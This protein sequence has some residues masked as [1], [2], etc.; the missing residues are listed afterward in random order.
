MVTWIWGESAA[1]ADFASGFCGMCA[2]AS[3]F[4]RLPLWRLT[5]ARSSTRPLTCPFC[6][7]PSA[8]AA[9]LGDLAGEPA[10]D[11]REPFE[12]DRHLN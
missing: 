3:P 8:A 11:L 6:A 9:L 2:S 1:A 5:L 4:S 10:S 7:P 12:G